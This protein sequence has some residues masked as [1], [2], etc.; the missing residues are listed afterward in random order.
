MYI[1][2]NVGTYSNCDACKCSAQ[3][4]RVAWCPC[5]CGVSTRS[6]CGLA[7]VE[8]L[9]IASPTGR[10]SAST[11]QIVAGLGAFCR[12]TRGRSYSGNP[13]VS[14]SVLP[15]VQVEK[16][17]VSNR[18]LALRARR[19]ANHR[20]ELDRGALLARGSDNASRSI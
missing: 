2:T 5:D 7:I 16:R 15:K 1:C 20:F 13:V 18:C 9:A 8:S 19:V 12:I 4:G 6:D 14:S 11:S 17:L 3:G 10:A